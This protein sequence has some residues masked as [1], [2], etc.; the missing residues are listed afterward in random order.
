MA[1]IPASLGLRVPRNVLVL[2]CGSVSRCLQPLLL[3]H[4]DMD[5]SGLTVVDIEDLRPAVPA[6]LQAG[7][8]FERLQLTPGNLDRE[9]TRLTGPSDLLI[10]LTTDIDTCEI[11]SWCHDHGLLYVDASVEVWDPYEGRDTMDPPARTLYARHMRLGALTASWNGRG[12]TAVLDH[13]ANPG[14]VSHWVRVALADVAT[15]ILKARRRLQLDWARE[16]RLENLLAAA[17]F[18]GLARETGTKVIH[19]SE[20]DTQISSRPKLPGEFVN[21]WS[22]DGFLEEGMAPAELG[23]GTHERKRPQDAWGHQTG[24]RNQICLTRTGVGTLVRS[25]VPTTGPIE[26]YLVRHGEAFTISRYLTVH[27]DGEAVYRPTVHYA[28]LPAPAAV[29]SWMECRLQDYRPQHHQRIMT[30]DIV[31]GMDELGVLL[32]GHDLNGWWTGSQLTIQET[33]QLV[34]MGQNATTLQVAASILGAIAWILDHPGEGLC[35]P[36]DLDHEQVLRVAGPYLGQQPSLQTDWTP[37]V[38]DPLARFRPDSQRGAQDAWQF[39]SFLV[40]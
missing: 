14:L 15:A 17:D 36:E 13:G 35:T 4:L 40:N 34:G 18:P 10:N 12:P 27:E 3:H 22:V 26:G 21:T 1:T 11:V 19:I 25:W 2:G 23:W 28:Y 39:A 8:R 31:T 29:R 33:R 6:T 24:P 38:S 32:L 16:R 37:E 20:E 5:F 7:A 30:D 9:L